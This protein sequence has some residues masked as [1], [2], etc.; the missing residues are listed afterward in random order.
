MPPTS[1]EHHQRVRPLLA[2][3]APARTVNDALESY[4][5]SDTA[6][7]QAASTRTTRN[8]VQV[9][10]NVEG[11]TRDVAR[12]Q[13]DT[14]TLR[15][16]AQFFN[17]TRPPTTR[18]VNFDSAKH[19]SFK[20]EFGKKHGRW[21]IRS[22]RRGT[23]GNRP[24]KSPR[25]RDTTILK[26]T[27]AGHQYRAISIPY[28][29]PGESRP[30][31]PSR[32][33]AL[34]RQHVPPVLVSRR[35]SSSASG[36]GTTSPRSSRT[37][38]SKREPTNL[39]AFVSD[40][41]S[42]CDKYPFQLTIRVSTTKLGVRPLVQILDEWLQNQC[43]SKKGP[44]VQGQQLMGPSQPEIT[45]RFAMCIPPVSSE[46]VRAELDYDD[47]TTRT[48]TTWPTTAPPPAT[49][50]LDSSS[51]PRDE[52]PHH[53]ASAPMPLPAV[54]LQDDSLPDLA[55]RPQSAG[56]A[57]TSLRSP[58]RAFRVAAST[59]PNTKPVK[60]SLVRSSEQP[61]EPAG[62]W[63]KRALEVPR[64]QI[65]P[66]S[67]GITEMLGTMT[68]PSPPSFAVKD[69]VGLPG[70][71]YFPQLEQ[72]HC[73]Q[74]NRKTPQVPPPFTLQSL[75]PDTPSETTM[76]G[77]QPLRQASQRSPAD[78]I[79]Q[80]M[81]ETVEGETT[82][83]TPT[84]TQPP[85]TFSPILVEQTA[86]AERSGPTTPCL[87][88]TAIMIVANIEAPSHNSTVRPLSLAPN[89]PRHR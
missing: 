54:E 83:V 87:T 32:L 25:L 9:D 15:D 77:L 80:L 16:L 68:F 72:G 55:P 89:G 44:T 24:P 35:R 50:M 48:R 45:G 76:T 19:C 82:P 47:S 62:T 60:R 79:S 3:T 38:P 49:V 8:T 22:L 84:A 33:T 42:Q 11:P 59:C 69:A 17:H 31:F 7:P 6:T 21:S 63:M 23:G 13:I 56:V 52:F 88:L 37:Q 10:K 2:D 28:N 4:K 12:E 86:P 66:D 26:T 14:E 81:P 5:T 43:S 51:S 75:A 71:S 53:A 57:M 85:F 46:T 65:R 39:G 1:T 40:P 36:Q 20:S 29:S 30:P 34:Q 58:E 74:D 41:S 73:P 27:A 70:L 67:P 78:G 64:L 18:E 61:K